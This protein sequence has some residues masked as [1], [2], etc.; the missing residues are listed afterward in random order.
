M[1]RPDACELLE[2]ARET[3]LKDV[4][5]SVPE[6]LRYEVRMIA[7]GTATSRPRISDRNT[8]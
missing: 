5:P 7:R 8:S 4:L 1:N 2:V 6:N 3:L